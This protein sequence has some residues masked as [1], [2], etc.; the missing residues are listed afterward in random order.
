MTP[1]GSPL[2]LALVNDF[3]VVVRGLAEM[4]APHSDRVE[5]VELDA[6]VEP[7]QHVDIALY[8][9][10]AV[11]QADGVELEALVANERVDRVVVF[12]WNLD[13]KL[14]AKATR[15]GAAGY[16]SKSLP[17]DDLVKALERVAAGEVVVE[18]QSDLTR[19]PEDVEIVDGDWP[20]RAEGLTARQ[21][22]VVSLI[23]QGFSNADI[24]QRTF[25]TM[26]TIKSYI[27]AAYQR[28]GVTSRSQAVIW[29]FEHGMAPEP[30]RDL[31]PEPDA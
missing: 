23:T 13:P 11:D 22:E 14:V 25:V 28:M 31:D 2:R 30:H 5:I 1:L 20:G 4:L 17:S 9:T 24:A 18:P 21:A 19:R 16:L 12:S 6:N 3:E 27:R 10:F 8:D 29:G 15:R 26:N 7:L